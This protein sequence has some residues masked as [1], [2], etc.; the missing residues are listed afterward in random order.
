MSDFLGA[1]RLEDHPFADLSGQIFQKS[2]T[3]ELTLENGHRRR[4]VWFLGG[5]PV[6]V[7][8]DEGAAV[9]VVLLPQPTTT[10]AATKRLSP[11]PTMVHRLAL[12]RRILPC[13][14]VISRLLLATVLVGWLSRW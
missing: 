10:R 9:V 4:T 6:A 12:R 11:R 13:I 7:V 2:L 14:A 1:G 8:S 3:G 5:N